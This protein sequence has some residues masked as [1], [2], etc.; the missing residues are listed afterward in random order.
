MDVIYCIY[1]MIKTVPINFI[2][3]VINFVYF[4]YKVLIVI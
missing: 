1:W 2:N 4:C 3:V